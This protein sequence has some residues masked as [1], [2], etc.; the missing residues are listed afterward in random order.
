M[1]AIVLTKWMTRIDW[2]CSVP[3]YEY[4]CEGCGKVL[5]QVQSM[6]DKPLEVCPSCGG[7]LTRMIS[8]GAGFVMKHAGALAPCGKDM[9]CC[10]G[11]EGCREQGCE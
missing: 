2:G 3:T 7:V 8:G 1:L 5:E 9:R 6:T 4:Q 11:P 10:G